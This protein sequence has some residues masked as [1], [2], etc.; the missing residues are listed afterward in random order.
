MRK[1]IGILVILL[2]INFVGC[3]KEPVQLTEDMLQSVYTQGE[4]L[5]GEQVKSDS[6]VLEGKKYGTNIYYANQ[7][8]TSITVKL[9]DGNKD[10]NSNTINEGD[11]LKVDRAEITG[12][13]ECLGGSLILIEID[14]EDIEVIKGY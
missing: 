8:W 11:K 2:S 10:K 7:D 9:K 14:N 13:T 1:I 6:I 5:T 3:G 4:D 12:M